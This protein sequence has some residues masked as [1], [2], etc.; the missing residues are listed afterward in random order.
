VHRILPGH[1]SYCPLTD[2]HE[3]HEFHYALGDGGRGQ[4][5]C[6]GI[7]VWG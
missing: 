4:Y 1:P 7:P 5:Y 3:P 2:R 6:D